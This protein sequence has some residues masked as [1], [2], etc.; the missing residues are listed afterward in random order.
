MESESNRSRSLS[1]STVLSGV[2][3]VV[4]FEDEVGVGVG[5]GLRMCRLHS[6]A[7]MSP[8]FASF[9]L[10]PVSLPLDLCCF[11][12][13]LSATSPPRPA[14]ENRC[15]HVSC[16]RLPRAVCRTG[17]AGGTERAVSHY[18]QIKSTHRLNTNTDTVLGRMLV[19]MNGVG[20]GGYDPRPAV[21]HFLRAKERR[22][23]N[24]TPE[25]YAK[26]EFAKSFFRS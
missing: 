4:D 22:W 12:Y 23:G 8:C 21:A 15:A 10:S 24:P 20:V 9:H 16:F 1:E 14:H 5:V 17:P 13:R 3:V 18:N 2:G 19:S 11:F 6:P 7:P 25:V 26:Q